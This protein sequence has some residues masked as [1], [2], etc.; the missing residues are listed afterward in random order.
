MER[1]ALA[2]AIALA[3]ERLGATMATKIEKLVVRYL[4]Q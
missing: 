3:F 2:C 4:M 1:D